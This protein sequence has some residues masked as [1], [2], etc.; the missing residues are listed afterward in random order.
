MRILI[1]GGA[2]FIGSHLCDKY[3]DSPATV[4]CYDNFLSGDLRN[5]RHLLDCNNFKLIKGDVRDTDALEK[6]VRDVDVIFHLAAQIHVDR[7][8]VEPE[9]TWGINVTG[10]QNVLEL[11]RLYDVKKVIFASSSEIYG[12]AQKVP[13]DESHPLDAPHPYGASKIA[14]DR[15]CHSYVQTY[16]MEVCVVRC[17][18]VFGPRQRAVGYGGVISI[19]T[20]RALSNHPLVIFGN[21]DQVRDYTYISDVVKAYD[22]VLRYDG[23]LR[24]PVNFGT[25]Q[26]VSIRE[27]AEKIIE[28]SG[29]LACRIAYAEKRQSE[30]DALVCDYGRA[31]K[32][33]GWQP[34]VSL[35]DGLSLFIEWY[36]KYGFQDPLTF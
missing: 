27:L 6:V 21:G 20:S 32:I 25:G 10:T 9:L 17:F 4:I 13:M 28:L 3:V 36:E 31:F 12:T 7:S 5:I 23:T 19:F 1:T 24:V 33:F 2:G 11:A 16:G 35:E 34:E 26:K 30:V 15:L 29:Y 14:A 18:N 8:Y 22:A